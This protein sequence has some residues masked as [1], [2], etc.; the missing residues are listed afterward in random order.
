MYRTRRL[1]INAC[2]YMYVYVYTYIYTYICIYEYIY[3]YVHIWIYIHIYKIYVHIVKG[4]NGKSTHHKRNMVKTNC[5]PQDIQR[6]SP[7]L[8]ASPAQGLNH[9][10]I[11][12]ISKSNAVERQHPFLVDMAG[13]D[14]ICSESW[15]RPVCPTLWCSSS[16]EHVAMILNDVEICQ[17]SMR[18]SI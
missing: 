18:I 13:H 3:I 6:H 7:A 16:S 10:W 1:S 2:T 11:P 17:M 15:K 4:G 14:N 12:W 8:G 9:V 5:R